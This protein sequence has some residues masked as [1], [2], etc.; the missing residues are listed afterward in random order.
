MSQG[1][2]RSFGLHCINDRVSIQGTL[3]AEI[4]ANI[5][6]DNYFDAFCSIGAFSYVCQKGMFSGVEIGRYCSVAQEVWLGPPQHDTAAFSTHP[7]IFDHPRI[8]ASLR[9]DELYERVIG[10]SPYSGF[11]PFPVDKPSIII[12]NDVWIGAR[13]VV[14]EGVKVGDGAVI[15]AGA[16]VTKDVAP[17]TIVGGVPARPIR[18]RFS[19]EII[20]QLLE[21]QWW[22]YDMSHVSNR[23][24]YGRPSEV[25]DFMR[26]LIAEGALPRFTPARV[27]IKRTETG[28][29]IE[30]A[31]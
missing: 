27:R 30:K 5:T 31:S 11:S 16:V 21:L 19:D 4:P 22:R 13:A 1:K 23:V 10:T 3:L 25:V 12:G 18:K 26:A 17:Y 2:L 8:T 24:D 29:L 15:A 20:A 6:I 9:G 14:M 7:F 28:V